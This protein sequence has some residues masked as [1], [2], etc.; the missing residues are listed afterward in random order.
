MADTGPRPN[1]TPEAEGST[2]MTLHE[3]GGP[4]TG[5]RAGSDRKPMVLGLGLMGVLVVVMV[6]AVVI[7]VIMTMSG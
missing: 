2:P 7:G 6:I 5:D 1:E 4:N 3:Q